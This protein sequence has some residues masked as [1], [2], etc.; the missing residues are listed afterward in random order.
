MRRWRAAWRDSARGGDGRDMGGWMGECGGWDTPR[1][2][3]ERSAVAVGP[4]G[5]WQE[6]TAGVRLCE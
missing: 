6:A 2:R 5:R 4:R 1:L 3:W